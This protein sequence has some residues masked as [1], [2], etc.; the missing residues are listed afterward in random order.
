MTWTKIGT[1]YPHSP[2]MLSVPPAVR[3][4]DLTCKVYCNAH[5]T[6][7]HILAGA[8]SHLC[9]EPDPQAAAALLVA[10]GLWELTNTGYHIV[11]F[12]D[13]QPSAADVSRMRELDRARQRKR[14]LHQNGDHSACDSRYCKLTRDTGASHSVIHAATSGPATTHSVTRDDVHDTQQKPRVIP[15]PRPDRTDPSEPKGRTGKGRE[16][17][18]TA[19]GTDPLP[20]HGANRGLAEAEKP[21]NDMFDAGIDW[22]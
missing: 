19:N 1:E 9:D 8:L 18:V 13:D 16:G 11:G 3:W 10:A 4:L 12:L 2:A 5:G 21:R 22:A 7:G 20:L 15:R 17:N 14:R 6:D